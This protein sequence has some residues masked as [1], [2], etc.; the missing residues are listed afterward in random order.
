MKRLYTLFL[1]LAC[2]YAGAPATAQD[3]FLFTARDLPQSMLYNPAMRPSRG[4][5]TIPLFGSLTAGFDNSFSYDKVIDKNAD[6]VKYLDT[7]GLLDATKGKDLTLMRFNLDLVNTGFFVGP[8]DYMGVSLRARAH[9][10]T[11]MPEGLFGMILDNPINEYKTFDVSMTPNAI[12]WVELGVSYTRDIDENWRVGGRLKYVNGLMSVQSTG[13]D[14]TVRKEY[15]RYTVTGDYALRGGNVDFSTGGGL[16]EDLLS[17]LSSNPGFAFDLGATYR[18][19]DKRLNVAFS[20]AD[21]GAVFWNKKNSSVIRTHSEGRTYDFYGVDG[22]GGLIDGTTSIGHVLDS[23]YTDL[24]R[25]LRADTTAGSFAQMLPTTFQA[26]ADYALG[27]YMRHHVSAGFVGMIP[28]HGKLHY[29]ISAGYAYR[30]LTGTWQLMA[31]YT[32]KSNNP[33]NVGLG[34]VMNTG[35]FQLYLAMDNI[36]PAFTL[37]GA[38]GTNVS[39]GLNFFTS[40]SREFRSCDHRTS[41]KAARYYSR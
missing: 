5:V 33:V 26:A 7:R 14:V 1:L 9:M 15:D 35:K 13:M 32:Y 27:P 12:G 2:G 4:F 3:H 16:F 30:T 39:L 19:N 6:G 37:T 11:S 40:R 10:A 22:L 34:V 36:I 38:R 24:S 21:L 20:V 18:S 29:A 41:R 8:K 25:T 17:N 31:N 23:A 28:Y